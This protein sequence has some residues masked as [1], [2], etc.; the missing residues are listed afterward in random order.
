MDAMPVKELATGMFKTPEGCLCTLGVIAEK[1]GTDLSHLPEDPCDVEPEDVASEL[2]IA[3][4]LAAEIMF[5]NDELGGYTETPATRW[6]RMRQWVEAK[7]AK[8][9]ET[10]GC[11][12]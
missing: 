8:P 5:L 2:N 10:A 3:R 7:I 1:R 6:V 4:A 9:H 11:D 12:A